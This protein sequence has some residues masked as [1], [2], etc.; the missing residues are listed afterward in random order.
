MHRKLWLQVSAFLFVLIQFSAT[1]AQNGR[2]PIKPDPRLTPGQLCVVADQIRYP[3]QIKYCSRDVSSETKQSIILTYDA[4]LGYNIRNQNRGD[5]KIDHYIPL[6]MGGS[7][8]RQNLWPQHESVY[9]Y[10]DP[11][12][13]LLC[14]KM[15]YGKIK[16]ANAIYLI[17]QA[18]NDL[19]SIPQIL[20]Y[21]SRL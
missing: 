10:T 19:T 17:R 12:E 14:E 9:K 8:E 11:L 1:Y 20:R 15:K 18:K 2:Y 16:Q 5:F 7:N 13:G 6:C 21:V 3:E 4:K